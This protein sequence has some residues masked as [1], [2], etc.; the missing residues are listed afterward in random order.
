MEWRIHVIGGKPT[1][2][3]KKHPYAFLLNS[4]SPIHHITS[5]HIH[6]I[7]SLHIHHIT[8]HSISITS[9]IT[10]YP[11]HHITPI[12]HITHHSISITSHITPYPSHHISIHIHHSHIT[13]S[14]WI[15]ASSQCCHGDHGEYR[16]PCYNEVWG[17]FHARTYGDILS[18]LF[19]SMAPG[20]YIKQAWKMCHVIQ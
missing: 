19:I 20:F 4:F 5:L 3:W 16:A 9:H 15:E 6:H 14:S 17:H 7:T 2:D 8:H 11:S 18:C 10:P 1:F 12:H 13:Q